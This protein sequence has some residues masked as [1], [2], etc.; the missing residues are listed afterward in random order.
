M[1][2]LTQPTSFLVV[3]FSEPTQK[4][5]DPESIRIE[6]SRAG[7]P[8]WMVPRYAISEPLEN[9]E[10]EDSAPM[11][12]IC[13]LTRYLGPASSWQWRRWL[14]WLNSRHQQPENCLTKWGHH[15]DWI[16]Y[17]RRRYPQGFSC[18]IVSPNQL[19]LRPPTHVAW[20]FSQE[21]LEG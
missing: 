21:L 18:W 3:Q 7:E 13:W 17:P 11:M 10:V 12:L 4:S 14:L 20:D 6:K 16:V 2:R 19:G 15:R 1:Q 9:I 5:E 8:I